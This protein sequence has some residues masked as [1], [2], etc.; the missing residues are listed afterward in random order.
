MT[1]DNANPRRR[2]GAWLG[3]LAALLLALAGYAY[4]ATSSPSAS[5]GSGRPAAGSTTTVLAPEQLS[6]SSAA[7]KISPDAPCTDPSNDKCEH[8]FG[9][10]VG[11]TQTLYPGLART[12]PVTYSN[13]YSFDI[14]VSSY[15]VTV[16]VDRP[17]SCAVTNLIVTGTV[18]LNPKLLVAR[19]SSASTTI[20]VT[21]AAGAPNGCQQAKFSLTV[22]AT[23]VKK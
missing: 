23:G 12:L 18:N 9:V 3:L 7:G 21:L 20:P 2:R 13:P 10:S 14:L 8:H 5:T 16:S 4:A 6:G 19:S 17:A 1:N 22:D 15:R 11:Q